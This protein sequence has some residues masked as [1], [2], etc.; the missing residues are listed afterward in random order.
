MLEERVINKIEEIYLIEKDKKLYYNVS[1]NKPYETIT[2][3]F[4]GQADYSWKLESSIT[5]DKNFLEY[6]ELE[7][8]NFNNMDLFTYIAKCQHY[9]KK[10]RFLDFSTNIDVALFFACYEKKHFDKD[11]SLFICPYIP[12]K[13]GWCD[14]LIIS[15]LSLL[16]TEI[17]V[18][19]F[20]QKLYNKYSKIRD[21]F[22]NTIELATSIVSWLD[23][24]F[25]VLPD[26]EEY[27]E[28]K[29]NNK[30][31]VVQQGAFFICGNKTKESLTSFWRVSSHVAT[32]VILPRIEEVPNTIKDSHA[33]I[34]I[35]I[36]SFLKE[37]VLHFLD[38][39]GI[40]DKT[41]LC[42]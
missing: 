21:K 22:E 40:N 5:R 16:K 13:K 4:R 33:V 24:G 9:G 28:L 8:F 42:G 11:A 19:D 23:H 35:R 12:R 1:Q 20:S 30:R 2:L 38:K 27:E 7:G 36:P 25:I 37:E 32:N 3:F 41:L 18:G 15:E 29:G 34:K 17:T 14:T 10:T 39:K 6:E 31:I 26:E